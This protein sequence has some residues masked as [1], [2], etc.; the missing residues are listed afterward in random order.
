MNYLAPLLFGNNSSTLPNSR[1]IPQGFGQN[2]AFLALYRQQMQG[3]PTNGTGF[4]SP[5]LSPMA[6]GYSPPAYGMMLPPVM[7]ISSMSTSYLSLQSGMLRG[8]T[9]SNGSATIGDILRALNPDAVNGQATAATSEQS[10]ATTATTTSTSPLL[11][12]LQSD[13]ASQPQKIA[14]KFATRID[15][16]AKQGVTDVALTVE[17]PQYGPIGID[18]KINSTGAVDLKLQ[19]ENPQLASWLSGL[20]SQI[21]QSLDNNGL[22]L[23]S[24]TVDKSAPPESIAFDQNAAPGQTSQ[25]SA[26]PFTLLEYYLAQAMN[27][28][29]LSF[30]S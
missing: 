24:L 2:G 11:A 30:V 10:A 8:L 5:M 12:A 19:T 7:P 20:K 23:R 22:S 13:V 16:L 6:G 25:G 26:A 18:L 29:A 9:S 3:Y 1:N 27:Q 21:Q 14:D 17:N 4:G 15:Q 28:N